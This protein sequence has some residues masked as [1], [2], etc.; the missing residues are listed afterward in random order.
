MEKARRNNSMS[1]KRGCKYERK[2]SSSSESGELNGSITQVG[3][4]TKMKSD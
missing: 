4:V 2:K 1:K 3:N